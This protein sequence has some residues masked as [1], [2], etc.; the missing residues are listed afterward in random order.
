M[1]NT[2]LHQ[3]PLKAVIFDLGGVCVG[4][5]FLAIATYEKAHHIP[6]H[7]INIAISASGPNGPFQKFERNEITLNEFLPAFGEE[8][9]KEKYLKIYQSWAVK[10][11]IDISKYDL[12]KP[13]II[14]GESLFKDMMIESSKVNV[15][16]LN[17]IRILKEQ[18]NYKIATITNNFAV[19]SSPSTPSTFNIPIPAHHQSRL[20]ELMSLFD[21]TIESSVEGVRKP[22][23]RIFQLCCK[24]LDL[25]PTECVFLD[26]IGENLKAA[27]QL[28]MKVISWFHST[29]S[30]TISVMVINAA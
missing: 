27:K 20:S 16:M 1:N 25:D 17:A 9:S 7:Y 13:F 24:R 26:D 8:L 5:P 28:G 15:D 22:D 11:G 12:T 14:D 23:P 3:K 19:P 18:T 29:T 21:V 2:K 6:P 10:K 30:F 4:S